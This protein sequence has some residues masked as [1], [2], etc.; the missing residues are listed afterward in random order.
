MRISDDFYS[1]APAVETAHD[2]QL[3]LFKRIS[4]TKTYTPI[5]FADKIEVL[6]LMRFFAKCPAHDDFR[7]QTSELS[8]LLNNTSIMF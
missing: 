5:G 7:T 8:V 3:E 4:L 2:V 6:T 1:A